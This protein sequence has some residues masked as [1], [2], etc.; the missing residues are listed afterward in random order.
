MRSTPD[1][2]VI[3]SQR[4]AWLYR[5][6]HQLKHALQ[7]DVNGEDYQVEEA[8]DKARPFS[9]CL[10]VGLATTST[11][12]RVFGALKGALDGGLLIPHS[13]RRW[14]AAE[15][16]QLDAELRECIFDVLRVLRKGACLLRFIRMHLG[17][18]FL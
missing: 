3:P 13:V 4:A 10:D 18:N 16:D 7:E 14:P 17:R 8:E 1:R 6:A 9:V 2:F 11:G 15:K 12:A 5:S